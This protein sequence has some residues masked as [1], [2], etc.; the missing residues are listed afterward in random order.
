MPIVGNNNTPN[1]YD[2]GARIR[3]TLRVETGDKPADP[4]T[5]NVYLVD[6][7]GTQT[8]PFTPTRIARGMYE[9]IHKYNTGVAGDWWIAW[10]GVGGAESRAIRR[11]HINTSPFTI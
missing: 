6:P 1:K 5:L 9:Y 11:I 7:T 2:Y 10:D 8:G 4:T 3:H